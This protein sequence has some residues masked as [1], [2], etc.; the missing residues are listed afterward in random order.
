M[1]RAVT[2]YLIENNLLN[3]PE[4]STNKFLKKIRI[5]FKETGK[6]QKVILNNK[7]VSKKI[8]SSLVN[9]SVSEVSSRKNIRSEMVKRQREIA[10]N[11]SV[12]M[13]GRDIGT[14][15]FPEANLKI[16][17]KTLYRHAMACLSIK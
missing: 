9:K 17:L 15:V 5:S 11:C 10:K 16:Y 4:H 7:D 2:L 13:D 12:V 6:H 1:Y 14:T 3:K 8:R